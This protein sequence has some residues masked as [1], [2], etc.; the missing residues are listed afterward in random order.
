MLSAANFTT[1]ERMSTKRRFFHRHEPGALQV[2]HDSLRGYL[3]H[4]FVTLMSPLSSFKPKGEGDG[5]G[6]VDGRHGG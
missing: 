3:G 2:P 4:G 6:E 5:V 1:P